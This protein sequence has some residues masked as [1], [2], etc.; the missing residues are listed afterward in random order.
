VHGEKEAG[1]ERAE[2]GESEGPRQEEP[3]DRRERVQEIVREVESKRCFAREPIETEAQESERAV[4]SGVDEPSPVARRD[5]PLEVQVLHQR[6]ALDDVAIVV[7][8]SVPEVPRR[9]EERGRENEDGRP[10]IPSRG[11][12]VGSEMSFSY[13]R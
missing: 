13:Q 10:D 1:R 11:P 5:E 12:A 4:E 7:D 8:E 2:G 6:V 3:D 9:G